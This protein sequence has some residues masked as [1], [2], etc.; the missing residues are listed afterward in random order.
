MKIS[1][2]VKE[3]FPFIVGVKHFCRFVN[4]RFVQPK[5]RKSYGYFGSTTL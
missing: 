3:N 4:V 5:N 1:T 2:F